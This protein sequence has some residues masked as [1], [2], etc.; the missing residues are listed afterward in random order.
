MSHIRLT[1]VIMGLCFAAVAAHGQTRMGQCTIIVYRDSGWG[2]LKSPPIYLDGI[3]VAALS[4]KSFFRVAV[5]P[6]KHRLWSDA[7]HAVE[8]VTE[9]GMDHYMLAQYPDTS[10]IK[11]F[12]MRPRLRLVLVEK[13]QGKQD[14]ANLRELDQNHRFN[15]A[16]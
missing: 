2:T 9:A 13:N 5:D 12:N 15:Q 4:N 7:K 8:V 3:Q 14:I 10:G 16:K 1:P 11:G 6:G